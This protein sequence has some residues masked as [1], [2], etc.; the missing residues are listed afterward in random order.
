MPRFDRGIGMRGLL[1]A[2]AV[3]S[4][5]GGKLKPCSHDSCSSCVD[6]HVFNLTTLRLGLVGELN[7][8]AGQGADSAHPTASFLISQVRS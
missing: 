3:A 6:S 5:I 1:L 2:A 8:T 7:G 4:V